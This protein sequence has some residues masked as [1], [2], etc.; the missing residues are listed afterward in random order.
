MVLG[1]HVMVPL[2][3]PVQGATAQHQLLPVRGLD[4]LLHQ[5]VHRR[6]LDADQ[7]AAA[8]LVRGGGMPVV[9][10]LIAR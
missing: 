9:P 7:V 4:D 1:D 5:I 2:Q 3:H 8:G 6:V 10:L